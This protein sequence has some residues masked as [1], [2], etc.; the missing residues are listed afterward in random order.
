MSISLYIH[1]PFCRQK[2]GYCDFIS[3]PY[4]PAQAKVYLHALEQEMA[5]VSYGLSAPQR[6]VK[7]VF[8]GGGTPTCLSAAQI[9]NILQKSREY[10]NWDTE[11]EVTVEA[12]PGTVDLAKLQALHQVG[13]NR[14]S[15]GAQ[16]FQNRL[17][18]TIGRIHDTA[19]IYQT[20]D[21]ARTAGFDNLSLDLMY[22]LPGQT[23]EDWTDSLQQAIQAK[24]E[25][26]SAYSL[27][28]EPGTPMYQAWQEQRLAPCDQDL[29]ADM[30]LEAC[31]QL[32]TA[33]Y[34]H[35]ELS[36]FALP[37][38]E[39]RHNLTYW[40]LEEYL[41]LGPAAHSLMGGYRLA[42]VTDL[43]IYTELLKQHQRP[44]ADKDLLTSDD[45]RAE[46]LFLG[47]RLLKGIDKADFRHSFGSE[48]KDLYG[49]VITKYSQ[50]GLLEETPQV[51]RLTSK[52]LLLANEVFAAFM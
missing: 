4:Q 10:F 36:N 8:L 38:R 30:Y 25:H 46:Y 20:F 33:G 19:A 9:A 52:G 12:N 21:Y 26:L 43:A 3:Y 5:L 48:L 41:A 16:A 22:G 39:C 50:L 49:E 15:I 42:N 14:L 40:Q 35:Y 23:M 7:T 18:Q 6:Q 51:L 37:G 45:A 13:V 11:V 17:L 27:K 44:L 28:L 2:C 29:E 24:V 32:T 1:I 34:T 31:G 47:L